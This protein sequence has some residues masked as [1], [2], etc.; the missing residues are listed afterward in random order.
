MINARRLTE[1]HVEEF[2]LDLLHR[3]AD[4]HPCVVDQ[5]VEATVGLAVLGEDSDHILLVGHVGGD[6]L[7]LGGG[8]AQILRRALEL[9]RSSRRD[10]QRVSLFAERP[11]YRQ[12][13]PTLS[14]MS[15]EDVNQISR[16]LN[17]NDCYRQSPPPMAAMKPTPSSSTQG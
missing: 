1:L 3:G 7:N 2:R 11:G 14:D 4:S 13:N 12:S 9:L 15:Q 10:R 8:V 6:A 16:G 5:N 17:S